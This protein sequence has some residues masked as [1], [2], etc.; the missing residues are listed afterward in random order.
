VESVIFPLGH[1]LVRVLNFDPSMPLPQAVIVLLM[2]I[3]YAVHVAEVAVDVISAAET[4]GPMSVPIRAS[5]PAPK[6]R[7][8][9]F[10]L[11]PWFGLAKA[12]FGFS[13]PLQD[14]IA[15]PCPPI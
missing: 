12:G 1:S 8:R 7:D 9:F 13:A 3:L 15:L 5:N 2:G 10:K 11:I 14:R 4:P 6:S